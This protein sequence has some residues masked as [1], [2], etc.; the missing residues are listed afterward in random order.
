MVIRG[1]CFIVDD[2]LKSA[3]ARGRADSRNPRTFLNL[4][5]RRGLNL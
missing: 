4:M 1:F 5:E 2:V 3:F